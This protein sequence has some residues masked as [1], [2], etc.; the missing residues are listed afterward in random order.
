MFVRG[1]GWS[2]KRDSNPRH[3]AWKADALPAELFPQCVLLNFVETGGQKTVSGEGWI[4]T[5]VGRS[6]QIYSLLPLATREPLRYVGCRFRRRVLLSGVLP[7]RF[8]GGISIP[9]EDPPRAEDQVQT[10][11]VEVVVA[12]GSVLR[13][14]GCGFGAASSVSRASAVRF[15][16]DSTARRDGA[17]GGARTRDL[18]ITNQLLYQLSYASLNVASNPLNFQAKS[19]HGALPHFWNGAP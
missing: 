12:A 4:R 19:K 9:P 6:R 14:P 15:S 18:L 7:F 16:S 10:W 11:V 13:V 8:R 17:G 5:N 2:G 1:L 3:S